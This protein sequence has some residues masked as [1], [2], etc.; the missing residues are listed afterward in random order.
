MPANQKT[1]V[2]IVGAGSI[3]I[4]VAYYLV[5][6]HGFTNVTLIDQGQPM[7]FTSAQSGEN[8]RDWWPHAPMV[9]FMQ[10]SISLMEEIASKSDNRIAMTRRGYVLATRANDIAG[11]LDQIARSDSDAE[12][13]LHEG[14]IAPT[15]QPPWLPDWP[16]APSGFDILSN[17]TLIQSLFPHYHPA[18]RH[19]IHVRRAGDISAQQLGQVM[20]ETIRAA[21][22][23][24][25]TGVVTGIARRSEGFRLELLERETR[26][27]LDVDIVVN[28]ARPFAGDVAAML[29]IDLP[30]Y[31]VVQQKIAFPDHESAIPRTMPFS[32]DLDGQSI[33]WTDEE[34][35]LLA[36]DPATASLAGLMPGAIHCRP[37]G[38][39]AGNWVK[40]G[41]AFNTVSEAAA[42]TP[43]LRADYPEIVLRGAARL[44]PALKRY[45]GRLPRQMHHYGGY[46]TRTSDNW[47]LIG[48]MGSD[49]A[50]M[51]AALSGHGTMGACA[52]GELTAAWIAGEELPTYARAFSMDRFSD[53]STLGPTSVEAGLL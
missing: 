11:H 37:D 52:T 42:R 44:N 30:I 46:Y 15:Y 17:Q 18:I 12:I 35:A 27:H 10:H 43:P 24:R 28:S 48:P 7:S 4:S 32:I 20:L 6:R 53:G 51:A 2:A 19:I 21:G 40:L 25:R 8:Y 9:Q 39:D 1:K 13:R 26:V 47:P 49:G 45:Y 16:Q 41:W 5:I 34:R 23:H 3:G 33:D 22:G 14:P 31:N 36:A 38:G 50:V 29:G